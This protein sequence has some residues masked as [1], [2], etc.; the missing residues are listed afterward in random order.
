MR[1]DNDNVVATL[2]EKTIINISNAMKKFK[3]YDLFLKSV[4]AISDTG[5]VYEFQLSSIQDYERKYISSSYETPI[6]DT[7]Y[8]ADKTSVKE[9][10]IDGNKKTYKKTGYF[11]PKIFWDKIKELKDPFF[12]ELIDQKEFFKRNPEKVS[13]WES[14][15]GKKWNGEK[16]A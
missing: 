7:F 14:I 5:A 11:V 15:M 2:S 6:N 1:T 10:I 4:N 13:I 12:S 3:T 9:V 8:F 16:F